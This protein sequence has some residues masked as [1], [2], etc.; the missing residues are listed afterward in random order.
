M[1]DGTAPISK[2]PTPPRRVLVTFAQVKTIQGFTENADGNRTHFE[3]RPG[4]RAIGRSLL[5]SGMQCTFKE[6]LAFRDVARA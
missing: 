6:L 2:R 4:G 5:H 3:P 1:A